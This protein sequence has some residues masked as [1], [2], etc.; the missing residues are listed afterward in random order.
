MV[1]TKYVIHCAPSNSAE[2]KKRVNSIRLIA[3]RKDVKRGKKIHLEQ[4]LFF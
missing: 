3:G 2:G 1:I 4:K